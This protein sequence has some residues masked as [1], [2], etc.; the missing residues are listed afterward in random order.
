[1]NLKK[2]NKSLLACIIL[3][4]VFNVGM[5]AAQSTV[6]YEESASIIANPER[7]LQ[8]YSITG[9]SY[10]TQSGY[11]SL[12]QSTLTEWR[13]GR[14][15][16]TVLFRYFLL[17]AYMETDISNTYL[18]NI[19]K[20]FD[21]IRNSGLKCIV[22]F[23]YSN[24]QSTA[25]QQP[26]KAQILR[27]LNQLSSVLSANK[28]VI[29]THQAGFIGTWGEWYY[30]NSSEFGNEGS[31]NTTQWAARKEIIEAMLAATPVEIPIQVRYPRV[32]KTMYG[33]SMLN[34]NT[35]Y[36]N[37]P[38]ARIGFFNDAFLN[39]WGDMGTYS[40]SG[41]NT[42]PVGTADYN[43]VAN[44]TKY[45]PMSGETNGLNAPRTGGANAVNEM[46]LTNWTFLNRDYHT[47]VWN[48]WI[49]D[50]YYDEILQKLGYRFVLKSSTFNIDGNTLNI[51]ISI[52]NVGFARMYKARKVYLVLQNTDDNQT[53]PLLL[54]TDPRTWEQSTVI[55]QAVDISSLP[56]G[57]YNSYLHLPDENAA[58]S[59]RPEY[60]VQ[61]AN[62]N[63]WDA[64]RGYNN[65]LQSI[66]KTTAGNS[67]L[68][69]D[70]TGPFDI[71]PNPFSTQ[72]VITASNALKDAKL[73]V[74]NLNGKVVAETSGISGKSFILNRN[75]LP[76][77]LYIVNLQ[78]NN[79]NLFSKKILIQ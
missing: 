72:A 40:V 3:L 56:K 48:V 17:N 66:S 5:I 79:S 26:A 28:D 58:L 46:N 31:I 20:D 7:G 61:M 65:L 57:T 2:S 25:P 51:N 24:G 21:I 73:T 42:T 33:N 29:V 49:N 4:S 22:R 55:S 45:T 41:Q 71:F 15:K 38:A 60:S 18:E 70:S 27:H 75:G 78:E 12:S 39:N 67:G 19:Q 69:G 10:N 6:N 43:Y 1:M 47:S 11:S 35:A 50:G 30:T 52:D 59:T 76:E 8:K 32:K 62:K 13:T 53:Y 14:D 37:T 44:E 64:E 36:Q 63:T 23:S 68:Q 9:S 74:M 16:V 54:D 77:G 34:E